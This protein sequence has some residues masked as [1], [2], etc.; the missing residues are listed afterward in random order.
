M[1]SV[2]DAIERACA[3]CAA[4]RTMM[5]GQQ[6]YNL[7][8]RREGHKAG[9]SRGGLT[10]SLDLSRAF[11]CLPREVLHASLRFAQVDDDLILILHVH[12]HSKI[13]IDHKDH[14]ILV[15]LHS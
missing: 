10:L 9:H 15:E 8:R 7:H 12:R 5:E 11:D 13:L 4:A 14:Q 6:K 1:R 3:H 2:E